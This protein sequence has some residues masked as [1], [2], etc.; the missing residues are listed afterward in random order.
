MTK[1]Q[2]KRK[3]LQ[4]WEIWARDPNTATYDDKHRFYFWLE[5]NRPELLAWRLTNPGTDR[6]QDVQGW[7]NRRTGYGTIS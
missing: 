7:L 4:E 3:I 1:E 6:W 2:C 5:E